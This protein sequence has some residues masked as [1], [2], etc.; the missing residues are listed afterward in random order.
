M[1]HTFFYDVFEHITC[2]DLRHGELRVI[3]DSAKRTKKELI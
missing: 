3:G 1:K 2:L